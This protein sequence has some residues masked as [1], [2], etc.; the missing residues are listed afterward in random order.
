M[1]NLITL[2]NIGFA[3]PTLP[4]VFENFSLSLQ[5]GSFTSFI[6]ASGCGKST[7]LRIIAGLSSVN[8]GSVCFADVDMSVSFVFQE[9]A[10]MPWLNVFENVAFP[11][12]IKKIQKKQIQKCTQEWIEKVGLK[13]FEKY[14]PGELSGGMKMRV[15]L[16]RAL[17]SEPQLLLLDEPFAAL[18]ELTR[19]TLQEELLALRQNQNWTGLLVTH[20]LQ[21]AV[22]FSDRIILLSNPPVRILADWKVPF[23]GPRKLS[24]M[25]EEKFGLYVSHLRKSMRALMSGEFS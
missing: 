2:Q 13:G 22:F 14:M 18:D 20:Q 17:V 19:E 12:K 1:T 9:A 24:L 4:P 3:Y 25:G 6:G 10:L 8:Q 21:E 5:K 7:L 11:L 15:S 23:D 16:A